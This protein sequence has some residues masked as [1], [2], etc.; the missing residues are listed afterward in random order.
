MATDRRAQIIVAVGDNPL[1]AMTFV[2]ISQRLGIAPIAVRGVY[3]TA[4]NKLR[5][6]TEALERMAELA[7][8]LE[9]HR[10]VDLDWFGSEDEGGE[11]AGESGISQEVP[12][13]TVRRAGEAQSRSVLQ[14]QMPHEGPSR[15]KRPAASDL[16]ALRQVAAQKGTAGVRREG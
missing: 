4:M 3:R 6:N 14:R 11:V 15:G 1:A 12:V 9:R 10:P 5:R 2:E 13:A 8:E 7:R 16:S